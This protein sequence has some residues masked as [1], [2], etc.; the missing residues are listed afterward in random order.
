[1]PR[2]RTMG[3]MSRGLAPLLLVLNG[4]GPS[5]PQPVPVTGAVTYNDKAVEV[6]VTFL[7]VA[8]TGQVAKGLSDKSGKF[9][10]STLAPEDGAFPGQYRVSVLPAEPPPMP[11]PSGDFPPSYRS[12]LPVKYGNPETSGFTADVREGAD[13][14][15][16]F[17]LTD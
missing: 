13:N 9:S 4:C 7:P 12:P 10:L 3:R 8:E 16:T 15:F 2:S 1:M 14:D 17:A 5:G 11:G 6:M